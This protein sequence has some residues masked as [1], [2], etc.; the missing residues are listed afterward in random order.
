MCFSS[1]INPTADSDWSKNCFGCKRILNFEENLFELSWPFFSSKIQ[2][3]KEK[4]KLDFRYNS[5]KISWL[6]SASLNL[7]F[8]YHLRIK[9][10]KTFSSWFSFSFRAIKIIWNSTNFHIMLSFPKHFLCFPSKSIF[11]FNALQV[12]T[13]EQNQWKS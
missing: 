1:E 5:Q 7:N 8:T 13:V 11:C 10:N 12:R 4:T 6:M 2:I 3:I 9:R